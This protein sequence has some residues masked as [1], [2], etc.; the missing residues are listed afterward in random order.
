MQI[1]DLQWR[2]NHVHSI[3][4][5]W[6]TLNWSALTI[7]FEKVLGHLDFWGPGFWIWPPKSMFQGSVTSNQDWKRS[8]IDIEM[9]FDSSERWRFILWNYHITE[10][11]NFEFWLDQTS[12]KFHFGHFLRVIWCSG[13]QGLRGGLR[14]TISKVEHS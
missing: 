8:K 6:R 10:P 7:F 13:V 9:I 5:G 2:K 1:Q 12:H 14:T 11:P 4:I 3:K